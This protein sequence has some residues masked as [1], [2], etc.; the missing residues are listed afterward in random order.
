VL[1]ELECEF[2]KSLASGLGYP[3]VGAELALG[4]RSDISGSQPPRE[5]LSTGR[6]VVGGGEDAAAT[7]RIG[8]KCDFSNLLP[9]GLVVTIGLKYDFP[10]TS[11]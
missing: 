3:L 11:P 7:E 1:L 9:S 2:P 5:A 4:V 6:V 8:T 10:T